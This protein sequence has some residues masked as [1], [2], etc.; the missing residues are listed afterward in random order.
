[1]VW[2]RGRV[3]AANRAD[4]LPDC[5]NVQLHTALGICAERGYAVRA[6]QVLANLLHS[7]TASRN[8]VTGGRVKVNC[9]THLS[10]TAE[11]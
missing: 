6:P 2:A 10:Q 7:R 3:Q 4:A 9:L 11:G 8:T 1:M 5:R